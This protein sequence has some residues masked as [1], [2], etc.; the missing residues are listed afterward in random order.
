MKFFTLFILIFFGVLGHSQDLHLDQELKI[1]NSYPPLILSPN[2]RFIEN[3]D[4]IIHNVKYSVGVE[5]N[6][7]TFIS[8]KDH[9]FKLIN[10]GQPIGNTLLKNK[11]KVEDLIKIDGWGYYIPI[12]DGWFGGLVNNT[13]VSPSSKIDWVFKFKFN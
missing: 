6:K 12:A 9:S 11:L 5:E 13:E 7:I 1:L 8:S 3:V 4:T 2:L 10:G